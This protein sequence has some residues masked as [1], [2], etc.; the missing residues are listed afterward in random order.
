MEKNIIEKMEMVKSTDMI[1]ICN[2][3]GAPYKI[4]KE[5]QAFYKSHDLKMPKRCMYCRQKRKG[6]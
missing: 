6:R 1:K 3:C 2:S 5:A 4:T